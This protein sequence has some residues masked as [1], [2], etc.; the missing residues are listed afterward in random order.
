MT[1]IIISIAL[2]GF[3]LSSS[4]QAAPT[5][6]VLM[7]K[8][9]GKMSVDY[10]ATT[11]KL[12]VNFKGGLKSGGNGVSA[13]YCTWVDRGF[14]VK[15]PRRLCQTGVDDVR[16]HLKGNDKVTR[17]SS[18]KAPYVKNILKG[19]AFQVRVYNDGAGCMKVTKAGV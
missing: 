18:S 17:L 6:Y 7:C 16:F 3:V 11:N 19:R 5:S 8:G 4:L 12:K 15:E 10:N 13:G 2:L 9:G 1:K 14:G